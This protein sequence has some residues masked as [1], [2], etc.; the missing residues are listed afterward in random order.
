MSAQPEPNPSEGSGEP[1]ASFQPDPFQP[2]PDIAPQTLRASAVVL[3][4]RPH[5]VS[6]PN[7]SGE[8]QYEASGSRIGA[9]RGLLLGL[10]VGAAL[11]LLIGVAVWRLLLQ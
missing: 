2:G 5:A 7:E 1:A 3:P 8:R 10:V 6:G 11:W 4:L 9:A